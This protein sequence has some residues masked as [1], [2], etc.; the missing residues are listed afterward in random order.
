MS[1]T[2]EPT[3]ATLIRDSF[4]RQTLM[5]SF[6]ASLTGL[7]PGLCEIT[8]PILP[9][10]RQQHGFA[11]AGLTFALGDSAAGYAALSVM[12]EGTEVLTVEMKINL[13][14][15]AQGAFLIATGKV[16]RPG[17]RIVVVQAEVEAR[18][19]GQLV[20]VAQLQ[21]TMIPVETG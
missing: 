5:E 12:P 9:S 4:A 13:L 21:G 1:F 7:A 3:R 2:L 14:A 11:H 15:P 10:A 6:G 8:A 19:D 18:H 17:K 20:P 16:L